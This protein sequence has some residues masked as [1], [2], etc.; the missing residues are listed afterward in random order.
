MVAPSPSPAL[1]VSLQ[2]H[3]S[4]EYPLKRCVLHLEQLL[5][6]AT[7]LIVAVTADPP[8]VPPEGEEEGGEE[9]QDSV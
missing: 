4:V 7:H 2:F 1:P 5:H 3:R 9:P 8:P 6:A